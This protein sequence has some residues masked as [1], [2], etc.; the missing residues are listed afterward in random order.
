MAVAVESPSILG[1]ADNIL[2]QAK[3]VTKYYQQKGMVAPTFSPNSC[4]VPKDAD[5]VEKQKALKASLEDLQRL[6]EGPEAFY[7]SFF[8]L[9]Y[10]IAAF[11][12][13][14]DFQFFSLVPAEGDISLE[15]LAAKAGLDLDRASRVIRLLT[16]QRFFEERKPGF[17]SH[18]SF[19][20]A[21]RDDELRAL[22]HYS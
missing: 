13:A 7:R 1:L 20:V 2:Q 3:D 14:L 10:D 12:I 16:T 6:V 5:F 15:D 19:S 18:N 21:M 4:E 11:Q 22:V 8:M 9:G 17:I